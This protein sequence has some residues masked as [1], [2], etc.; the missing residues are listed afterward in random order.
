MYVY[1][2]IQP[3]I[4]TEYN[5]DTFFVKVYNTI[6]IK[7]V[8]KMF[9]FLHDSEKPVYT[10]KIAAELLGCHPQTLR[11]YEEFGLIRPERTA[12]NYRMYSQK[13]LSMM[14]RLCSMMDRW[15]LNLSGTRALFEMAERF[16][17]EIE[18]MIDQMLE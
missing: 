1:L 8:V 15:E 13:N 18:K 3:L 14:K 9:R 11:I 6:T 2:Q 12:K 10:I 16:H 5:L 7:V 4:S 17:I